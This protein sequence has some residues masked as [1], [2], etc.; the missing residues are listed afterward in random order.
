MDIAFN[1]DNGRG[2]W[3]LPVEGASE[4]A[5]MTF[6]RSSDTLIMIDHTYVPDEA[7]GQG[8]A[9]KLAER[10][11]ADAREHGWKIIP[12][13]PFFKAIAERHDDWDDVVRG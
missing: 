2:R 5:E 8:L 6:S 4:D 9:K 12:V 11:V 7:R 1:E 10:A 13:C 3:S